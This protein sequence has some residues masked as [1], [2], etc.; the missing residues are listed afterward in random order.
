[1]KLNK[2][3][4]AIVHPMASIRQHCWRNKYG[5]TSTIKMSARHIPL[6]SNKSVF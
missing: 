5:K 3:E 2:N 4:T 6:S 1:M